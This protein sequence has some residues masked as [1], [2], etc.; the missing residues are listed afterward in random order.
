MKFTDM[1]GVAIL[2][3]KTK[4]GQQNSRNW[5]KLDV[6][7]CCP[8]RGSG[9]PPLPLEMDGMMEILIGIVANLPR[10]G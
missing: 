6:C 9:L 1:V 5:R 4:T 3:G 7:G 10:E 8:I 2:L